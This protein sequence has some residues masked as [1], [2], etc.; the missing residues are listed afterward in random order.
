MTEKLLIVLAMIFCI[1]AAI[2]LIILYYPNDPLDKEFEVF[3]TSTAFGQQDDW[4][5][6]NK[7]HSAE[8]KN[9]LTELARALEDF[10]AAFLALVA[11]C[12]VSVGL[13]CLLCAFCIFK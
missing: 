10:G 6:S 2:V 5:Y 7:D 11:V 1:V 13:T 12:C 4:E 3:D 9:H 8:Y